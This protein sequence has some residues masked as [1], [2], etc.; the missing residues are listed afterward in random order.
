MSSELVEK[1]EELGDAELAEARASRVMVATAGETSEGGNIYSYLKGGQ[2]FLSIGPFENHAGVMAWAKK[3]LKVRIKAWAKPRDGVSIPRGLE[4]GAETRRFLGDLEDSSKLLE[5]RL[6]GVDKTSAGRWSIYG[7][8]KDKQEADKA[9]VDVMKFLDDD[10]D[11]YKKA[12]KKIEKN[13]AAGD[14]EPPYYWHVAVT[15]A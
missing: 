5:K 14:G 10:V 8:A 6:Q 2:Y 7:W 9:V 12:T 4:E 1:L 15:W 11:S 3:W 13:R